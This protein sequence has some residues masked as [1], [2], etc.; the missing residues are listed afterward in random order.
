ML[1]LEEDKVEVILEFICYS[2]TPAQQK[3]F[4][5]P[6]MLVDKHT[7]LLYSGMQK[8]KKAKAWEPIWQRFLAQIQLNDP[9]KEEIEFLDET[10]AS[11][12]TFNIEDEDDNLA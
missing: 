8:L 12:T 10:K 1:D 11:A 5:R 6:A 3:Y 4:R 2:Q 7:T 9:F